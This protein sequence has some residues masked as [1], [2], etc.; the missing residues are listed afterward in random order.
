MSRKSRPGFTLIELL[1]VIAIIAVL[2]AL[3]LPAVQAAREAARRA[4]CSNNMKQ[5]GI[6]M[7]NYHDVT[8]SFPTTMWA[9]PTYNATNVR[10][11]SSFQTMLLPY[12]EQA[13]LY[14]SINFFFPIGQG[15]DNGTVNSTA[16]LTVVNV[17]MC[18]SDTSPSVTSI[19]RADSGVGPQHTAG[20]KLSY[21]VNA[22]DNATDGT[23][24]WPFTSLPAIRLNAFGD[25]STYTGIVGRSGGTTSIRDVTDG[26][27]NTFGMGESLFESCNWFSWPNP[28]G[29]YAF[30]SVP[31]NWKITVFEPGTPGNPV[32][33]GSATSMLNNSGNW[34]PGFGFR[35][36]H[37]GIVQFLF[38]DGRVG[39]IK[40]SINRN[41]YR[42]LST[43]NQGE[44]ISADAF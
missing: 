13:P 34:V 7:H 36:K 18:P 28:N 40:E 23:G 26:T 38:C 27:S 24:P 43:R 6:A 21:Y 30:T 39:V 9:G 16:Y 44:I 25:S 35:S 19:A 17:F 4:S 42:N 31:I 10:Y 5:F 29:C 14:N 3:L 1:V 33:Y 22:G 32:E 11:L 20:V 12:I 37:P 2:I 8:S 41:V 15:V